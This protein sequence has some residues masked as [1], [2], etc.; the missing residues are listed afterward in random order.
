MPGKIV[1]TSTFW[2]LV[3]KAYSVTKKNRNEEDKKLARKNS[4]DALRAISDVELRRSKLKFAQII[5]PIEKERARLES[6]VATGKILASSKHLKS[7]QLR[8]ADIHRQQALELESL[9]AAK[10]AVNTR[11]LSLHASMGK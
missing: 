8:I 4:P 6:D 11:K 1:D 3:G 5:T 10:K 9:R 2:G 7:V